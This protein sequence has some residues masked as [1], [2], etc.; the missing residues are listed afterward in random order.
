M[1][2]G[3]TK[4]SQQISETDADYPFK[5]LVK[6]PQNHLQEMDPSTIQK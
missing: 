4:S 5:Y 3:V 2:A 1:K 6:D